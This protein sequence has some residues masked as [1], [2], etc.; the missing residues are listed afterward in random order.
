MPHESVTADPAELADDVATAERAQIVVLSQAGGLCRS[1]PSVPVGPTTPNRPSRPPRIA[2]GVVAVGVDHRVQ[3][4]GQATDPLRPRQWGLTAVHAEL[5]WSIGTGSG[6]VVAVID[7]GVDGSHPDLT[8]GMVS[9]KNTRNDRG[10]Y[11]APDSDNNGHGTHVAGI[12][13]ARANNGKGIAGVAPEAQIMPVKVLDA[14]GSGWMADVIEGIVWAADH[15]A[16][17]I[18]MSL[19]GPDAD[20]SAA[21]VQYA[22]SRGVVVVAAAGNEGSTQAMYPA[23]L[24]GVVSVS[25]LDDS[26]AVDNYSNTGESI[27]IAAP[28]RRSSRRYPV[29]YQ[30]MSGTSMAAPHVAGVAALIRGYAPGADTAAVVGRVG[31]RCRS[32]RMG[33]QVRRRC[34]RRRRGAADRLSIVRHRA[35]RLSHARNAFGPD[36]LPN[37]QG[38]GAGRVRADQGTGLPDIAGDRG[39]LVE[40]AHPP[41]VYG[42]PHRHRI[43]ARG[44]GSRYVPATCQ[45]ARHRRVR[46]T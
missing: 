43:P 22:Q 5:A 1:R 19:G 25:A 11:S 37:G 10:D 16:D 45:G 18:N 9:G 41:E 29:G 44:L 17:V 15:G 8:A 20:F 27:D 32:R 7:S 40:V 28:G 33:Q 36:Q 38:S 42:R 46:T 4:L 23:A 2:T 3:S 34:G 24:P 26:G 39:D 21:A 13:A 12:I 35:G 31:R 14:D 6:A 30:S